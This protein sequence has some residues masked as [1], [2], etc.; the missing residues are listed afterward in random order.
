MKIENEN[1][2]SNR[3]KDKFNAR[4]NLFNQLFIP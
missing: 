1:N 2:Q 4:S 3:N